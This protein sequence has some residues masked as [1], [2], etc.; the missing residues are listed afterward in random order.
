MIEFI[1]GSNY[2]GDKYRQY[3]ERQ[4][5]LSEYWASIFLS[6][7]SIEKAHELITSSEK[8]ENGKSA[9]I[10][11]GYVS[12]SAADNE[13]SRKV[14][15]AKATK[16][17]KTAKTGKATKATKSKKSKSSKSSKSLSSDE[18]KVSRKTKPAKTTKTAKK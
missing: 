18:K 17:A 11:K 5:E 6:D 10:K 2:H 3:R 16:S 13:V 7:D 15:R 14:S 12:V 8:E 9:R 1:E 4:I